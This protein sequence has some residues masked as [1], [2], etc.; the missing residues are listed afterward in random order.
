MNDEK[1]KQQLMEKAWNSALEVYLQERYGDSWKQE[2]IISIP[3]EVQKALEHA[4]K[5]I[6]DECSPV[7]EEKQD[8]KDLDE[9][10]QLI[11]ERLGSLGDDFEILLRA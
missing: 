1:Q 2:T 8:V 6:I 5:Y 7:Q 9:K 11:K 3:G 4:I 10:I